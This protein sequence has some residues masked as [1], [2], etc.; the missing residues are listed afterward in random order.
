[1]VAEMELRGWAH[2]RYSSDVGDERHPTGPAAV[3]APHPLCDD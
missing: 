2:V 3:A 1:M